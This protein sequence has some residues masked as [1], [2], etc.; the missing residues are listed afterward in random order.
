MFGPCSGAQEVL[1]AL[2]KDPRGTLLPPPAVRPGPPCLAEV[3]PLSREAQD[4]KSFARLLVRRGVGRRAGHKH[5]E[6]TASL[7]EESFTTIQVA[8]HVK[9]SF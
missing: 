8:C 2:R 1:S 4:W 7:F 5:I 6:G 3:S 9:T